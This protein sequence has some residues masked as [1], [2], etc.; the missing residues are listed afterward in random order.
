MYAGILKQYNV[1]EAELR[2]T[3]ST[4]NFI[5]RPLR[6]KLACYDR[7][8]LFYL[9]IGLLVTASLGVIIGILVHYVV[10]MIVGVLYF[11]MLGVFVWFTKKNTKV[12]IRDSHL[13]MA[14][15]I[16]AENNRYYLRKGM[17]IRPGFLAKW[18]EF[19][20]MMLK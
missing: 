12:L 14:A 10:S 13:C 19:H 7:I 4:M 3:I 17:K 11:S 2:R 16:R 5:L 18:I 1:D 9:L 6:G 20:F 15:F 8:I